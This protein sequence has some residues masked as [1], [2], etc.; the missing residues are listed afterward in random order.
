MIYTRYPAR[1]ENCPYY[2][3]YNREEFLYIAPPP[4]ALMVAWTGAHIWVRDIVP[5]F[6][7]GNQWQLAVG[8]AVIGLL[9]A[10]YATYVQNDFSGLLTSRG[11]KRIISRTV[12]SC[13]ACALAMVMS[14]VWAIVHYPVTEIQLAFLLV[15]TINFVCSNKFNARLG[16]PGV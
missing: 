9:I 3:A 11:K 12:L 13:S 8:G 1:C 15:F 4:Y 16:T 10:V 6:E 2:L 14:Y 5:S 7:G